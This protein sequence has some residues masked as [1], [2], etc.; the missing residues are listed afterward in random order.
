MQGPM[1]ALFSEE[2]TS[3]DVYSQTRNRFYIDAAT[4]GHIPV[5]P[6]IRETI[7]TPK[8]KGEVV[9]F[10]LMYRLRPAAVFNYG[11]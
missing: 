8:K 11:R 1:V 10:P 9:T 4:S 3:W 6:P 5:P 2:L 7:Q